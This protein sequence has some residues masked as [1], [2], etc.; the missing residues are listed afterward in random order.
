MAAFNELEEFINESGV[1]NSTEID[2]YTNE[3]EL[4][5]FIFNP[6]LCSAE[7]RGSQDHSIVF[8]FCQYFFQIF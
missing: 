8:L 3:C 4:D 6:L 1:D 5:I 7:Y 2:N